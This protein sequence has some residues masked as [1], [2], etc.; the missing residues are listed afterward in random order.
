M[1]TRLGSAARLPPATGAAGSE[2]SASTGGRSTIAESVAAVAPARSAP[3][4]RQKRQCKDCG[5]SG[6]CPH[7]KS[8]NTCKDCG[9]SAICPHGTNNHTCKECGGSAICPHGKNRHTYKECG[10]SAICAHGKKKYTCEECGGS[11]ICP[12]GGGLGRTGAKT[13]AA[14]PCAQVEHVLVQRLFPHICPHGRENQ[15][16]KETTEQVAWGAAWQA[17]AV[18]IANQICARSPSSRIVYLVL[19]IAYASSIWSSIANGTDGLRSNLNATPACA[20]VA[21]VRVTGVMAQF[22]I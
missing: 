13:V 17:A 5:G 18:I 3:H 2:R 21:P 1:R 20:E 19:L 22:I 4:G 16:C 11:G 12:P 9:G 10:V 14:V 6:I 7:D 15:K 8:Q